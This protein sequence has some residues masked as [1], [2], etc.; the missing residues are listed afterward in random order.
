MARPKK[1]ADQTAPAADQTAD[2]TA[3]QPV[4]APITMTEFMGRADRGDWLTIKQAADYLGV[5]PEKSQTV[6]NA[7]KN[8]AE[9][10][11]E[12]ASL[13]V[14]IEG[15]D[16]PPLTYVSRAAVDLYRANN[17]AGTGGSRRTASGVKRYILRISEDQ[18]AALETIFASQAG[19]AG[20]AFEVAS[21]P[22]SKK[23]ATNGATSADQ[24]VGSDQPPADASQ[25]ADAQ[26]AD[27]D[28]ARSD[29]FEG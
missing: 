21:T 1:N 13:A 15:Y 24:P 20:L 5:D 11:A 2:Q 29:L 25:D 12:G 28:N 6:R 22:K 17:A 9:F 18:K 7:V 16:I 19:F 3:A 8:R 26:P 10:K 23:A 14:A 27:A 4:V